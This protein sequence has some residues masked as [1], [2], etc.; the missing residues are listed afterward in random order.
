MI[1]SANIQNFPDMSPAAVAADVATVKANVTLAGL[2]EIQPGEDTDVI[3]HELGDHWGLAGADHETPIV[4]DDRRWEQLD[5][6]VLPFHR[7]KGLPRPQNTHGAVTSAVFRARKR[8]HLPPFAVVNVHL[9]SGGY[10]GPK[11]DL[12]RSR[13]RVEW[14]MFRDECHRLWLTGLT[15]YAVGDLN[16]PRPPELR[17]WEHFAWLTPAGRPDHIGQLTHIESVAMPDD[18]RAQS[19][20]L[21]SDHSLQ[22]V[23]GPLRP[24]ADS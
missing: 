22:V 24:A 4:W 9:V 17:P 7:P 18:P 1:G 12:L 13:W 14:G 15:V 11:L 5:H 2:Q 23:S 6:R 10:N 20:P 3:R 19:V 8:R 16:N 21:N